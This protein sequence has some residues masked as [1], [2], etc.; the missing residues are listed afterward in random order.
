MF[1]LGLV[2]SISAAVYTHVTGRTGLFGDAASHLLHG[3]RVFDSITPGF[4][5]LGNYW[6]PLQHFLELPFVWFDPL[7]HS[8]WAGS[9]PAMAF[10]VIGVMGAYRLG[11]EL[12][13]DRRAGALAAFAFGA[14]PSLLYLQATPMLES[15][16]AMSLVWVVASLLRFRRTGR[17]R[18]VVVAGL[19]SSVAVW[20]T[21][22]AMI[23]PLY[24]AVVVAAACR[25]H[26]FGWRQTETFALAYALA[27]GYTLLLWMAWNFYIQHDPLYM[28]HYH[29]P[30]GQLITDEAFVA[31]IR[32]IPGSCCSTTAPRSWTC[33]VPSMTALMLVVLAGAVVRRRFLH[34]GGVA[35]IGGGLIFAYMT[36]EG[37]GDRLSPVGRLQGPHRRRGAEPEH[38]LRAVA[39]AVRAGGGRC[40]GRPVA[41]PAGRV[42]G[43]VVVRNGVVPAVGARR[44]H[45]R[46]R[47]AVGAGER[48]SRRTSAA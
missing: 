2:A 32:A 27:A 38:P 7:Y 22:G 11:V 40:A 47:C 16:I 30:V 29:Q 18:D 44:Q 13:R 41:A 14:N 33:S 42:L 31:G 20:S 9:L 21:W 6:P 10:Y 37:D 3:R 26:G 19:W 17:F 28:L 25:R 8:M 45:D 12:T 35:L 24:G 36:C 34:P 1:V 15:A 5:Q 23:L 43:L 46:P 39:G 4:G 48:S